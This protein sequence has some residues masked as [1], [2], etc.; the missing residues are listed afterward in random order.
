MKQIIFI[1]L[2]FGLIGAGCGTL[3]EKHPAADSIPAQFNQANTNLNNAAAWLTVLQDVNKVANVTPTSA[4]VDVALGAL[5]GIAS[6]LGGYITRH[7]TK[8][9]LDP[10]A[11]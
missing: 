3:F 10:P 11:K 2:V 4:P 1:V 9:S 5:I 7:K 6:A 8:T